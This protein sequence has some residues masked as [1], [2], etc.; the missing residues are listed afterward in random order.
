MTTSVSPPICSDPRV[1][2]ALLVALP[3]K[4]P[5]A[6]ARTLRRVLGDVLPDL[7]LTLGPD[8]TVG[9]LDD[10]AWQSVWAHLV[11]VSPSYGARRRYK[12]LLLE[13]AQ[14]WR[15]AG[16]ISDQP[17]F[18]VPARHHRR[19]TVRVDRLGG[20]R[21]SDY[22]R[23]QT[24]L[25]DELS[26]KGKVLVSPTL[27]AFPRGLLALTLILRGVCAHGAISLLTEL[28]WADV[29]LHP[30]LPLR[31]PR[32]G[33]QGW[34]W[35]DLPPLA[36]LFLLTAYFRAGK[37][38][39]EERVF[40]VSP[41]MLNRELR[42]L[43]AELCR[44]ANVP[45]LLPSQLI[46]FVR[47][48]LRQALS[49]LNLAV[50]T[51]LVK[52]TSVAA[53]QV[54]EVLRELGVTSDEL[55]E[56]L[57]GWIGSA[58]TVSACGDVLP[59]EPETE[60]EEAALPE[61]EE[62]LLA[63]YDRLLDEIRP[64]VRA[65]CQPNPPRRS[66]DFLEKWARSAP[67][68]EQ[69]QQD[70]A[71]FNLALLVRWLL[72]LIRQKRLKPGSRAVYWSAILHLVR[73]A[74][75]CGLHEL[76]ECVLPEL[77]EQG[78]LLNRATR[79]AWLRLNHFLKQ[80]GLP[81]PMVEQQRWRAYTAWRPA[82]VL[83]ESQQKALLAE[84]RGTPLGRACYLA[85]QAGLRV[86][87]VCR[88]HSKDVMLDGRPYLIIRRSKRGRSRRVGL[89]HLPPAHLERQHKHQEAR[90]REGGVYY[91]VHADGTPLDPKAI[92]EG[93]RGALKD[94]GRQ[95]DWFSGCG[96]RFHSWRAAAAEAFYKQSSDVRYV[97]V[98][99]G[100]SLV[101][102]T[103]GSY[104][105]TLDLQCAPL[106]QT[107]SSPLNGHNLYLPVVVF[108]TLLGRTSRRIV[109]MVGE[110]NEGRPNQPLA[111]VKPEKLP[112]GPRPARSGRQADYLSIT[113]ALRLV[114]WAIDNRKRSYRCCN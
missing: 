80:A 45:I 40:A 43:L 100:H 87:E 72:S 42:S 19:L 27:S 105:H 9:G 98:Q 59:V 75:V 101:A 44:A 97:A 84:L 86:S 13:A 74:P 56:N 68:V 108:A 63:T 32:R 58:E 96:L 76:G 73:T 67:P 78:Y 95:D 94:A 88:L 16:L 89:E 1:V 79:A 7:P 29:P 110:F 66:K 60:L 23:L 12:R 50:M 82:R 4:W 103:V 21:F 107:R 30:D 34:V 54:P 55:A 17:E 41:K 113:D 65:L 111:L 47:L 90:L 51:G 91:L 69:A 33:R 20:Y 37:P 112:D 64:H 26:G 2:E 109:Q 22:E 48:A 93:M 71:R 18:D 11:R 39:P 31:L 5:V 61:D 46:H 106:L 6:G 92:S 25:L 77:I 114:V 15:A 81:V 36:R 70:V 28:T 99:M 53:D 85:R 10:S 83:L 52:F 104:L 62:T 57:P 24:L 14:A 35:L 38:P 8:A 3:H 49:N 102:T